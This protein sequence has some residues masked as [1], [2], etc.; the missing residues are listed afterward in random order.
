MKNKIVELLKLLTTAAVNHVLRNRHS[1]KHGEHLFST[2][3]QQL[4]FVVVR[5]FFLSLPAL[6]LVDVF[7]NDK[8]KPAVGTFLAHVRAASHTRAA[9]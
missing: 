3:A 7:S 4:Y 2:H 1:R 9:P 8:N 5:S 6:G